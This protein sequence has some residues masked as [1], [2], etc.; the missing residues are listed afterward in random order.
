VIIKNLVDKGQVN[1]GVIKNAQ[2]Y[3]KQS[4]GGTDKVV[5]LINQYL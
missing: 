5:Q 3:I 4:S 1:Q 2:K